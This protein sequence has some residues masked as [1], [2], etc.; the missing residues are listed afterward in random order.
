MSKLLQ[1]ILTSLLSLIVS[2]AY[3]QGNIE[4][5][6]FGEVENIN[7]VKKPV[8]GFGAGFFNYLGEVQN[9]EQSPLNG[10]SGYKVN[11]STYI[12]EQ[13][14]YLKLNF[15]LIG[16]KLSG[17]ERSH[18]DLSRNLNFQSDIFVFGINMNYN[19]NN[20]Y[21]QYRKLHPF[22]SV[23]FEFMTFNSKI[24]SFANFEGQPTKYNYWSDGTIR[25]TEQTGMNPNAQLMQRDY[26]YE[27]DIRATDWGLGS[28]PQYAVAIPIEFGLDYQLSDRIMLR[29]ATSYHYTFT[30]VIDHVSSKNT[31][32]VIGNKWNDS[33][34]FTYATIHLDLFSDDKTLEWNK[35]FADVDFDETL[36]GDED[37]DGWRDGWDKCPGTPFGTETDSL[38]CPLDDDFDGVPNY[39]DEQLNTP[40]GAMVDE[41]GV[42]YQEDELIA[43]L[44]LDNAVNRDEIHLHIRTPESYANYRRSTNVVIPEK[45][46]HI[47]KDG[48]GYISYDEMMNAVDKFFD[49]ES[50]LQLDEIH[51]LN[52]FFF[53][54]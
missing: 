43:L 22:V 53:S 47:D 51:E 24:D 19:F 9:I 20:F 13:N 34:M 21:K 38:G 2:F 3:T 25:T 11:L 54:Q 45:F 26:T 49:F 36:M 18:S 39:K 31:T 4:D 29:L 48:D 7:A 16:G 27:T 12:N 52:E 50:T 35:L 32:G 8:V 23:G 28:Y 15:Y 46:T 40:Y 41:H 1:Y 17:N 37:G 42:E 33:F 44:S 5:L 10:T 14:T 6:M 30:D